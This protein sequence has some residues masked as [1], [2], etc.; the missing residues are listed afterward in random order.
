MLLTS[1]MT[2]ETPT[3]YWPL[4]VGAVLICLVI[5]GM[6]RLYRELMKK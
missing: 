1:L 5:Y 4:L 3:S 6:V 2:V